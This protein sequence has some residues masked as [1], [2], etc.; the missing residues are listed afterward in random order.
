M[1]PNVHEI[2]I[3]DLE[4]ATYLV[5]KWWLWLVTQVQMLFKG[6]CT[7]NGYAVDFTLQICM[8][9]INCILQ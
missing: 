4:I 1:F 6:N 9:N 2:I 8:Q 3:K 5:I 7:R